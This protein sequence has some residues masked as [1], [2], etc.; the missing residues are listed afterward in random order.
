MHG[1]ESGL[2]V[3][4]LAGASEDLVL[5]VT[6]DPLALRPARFGVPLRGFGLRD[7]EVLR[8]ATDVALRGRDAWVRATVRRAVQT[9]VEDGKWCRHSDAVQ[10]GG[11]R[12]REKLYGYRVSDYFAAP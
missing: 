4:Q 7:A 11:C 5:L 10:E 6:H 2:E 8:E 1:A 12:R 3:E 9:V